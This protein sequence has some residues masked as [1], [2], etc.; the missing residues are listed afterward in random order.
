[1]GYHCPILTQE[2]II[3]P[4]FINTGIKQKLAYCGTGINVRV[5][6]FHIAKIWQNI[7]YSIIVTSPLHLNDTMPLLPILCQQDMLHA[8]AEEEMAAPPAAWSPL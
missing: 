3:K 8:A 7:H 4:S 2:E 1:M 6:A 5:S